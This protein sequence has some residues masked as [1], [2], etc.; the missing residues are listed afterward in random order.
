MKQYILYEGENP[1]QV[2]SSRR[3]SDLYRI[4]KRAPGLEYHIQTIDMDPLYWIYTEEGHKVDCCATEREAR[5]S[6]LQT[7]GDGVR[8][9]KD[10]G[11]AYVL[12]CTKENGR[13][14]KE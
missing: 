11:N 14:V 12:I 2:L 9:Y 8:I 10:E 5:E 4:I 7:K 13:L 3:K 1:R 6:A